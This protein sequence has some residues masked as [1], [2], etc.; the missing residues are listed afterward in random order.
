MAA[1]LIR[2]FVPVTQVPFIS[3]YLSSDETRFMLIAF[4]GGVCIRVRRRNPK[5]QRIVIK[6]RRLRALGIIPRLV[7]IEE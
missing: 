6:L 4:D 5:D 3:R 2:D 7:V 1:Y